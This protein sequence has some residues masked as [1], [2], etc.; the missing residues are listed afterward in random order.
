MIQL[1][2]PHLRLRRIHSKASGLFVLAE[3]VEEAVLEL[4]SAADR[5]VL[6]VGLWPYYWRKDAGG[7]ELRRQ[8]IRDRKKFSRLETRY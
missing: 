5:D 7:C 3:E 8:L 2:R 4:L 1:S 6:I